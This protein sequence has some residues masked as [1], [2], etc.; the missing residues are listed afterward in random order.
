MANDSLAGALGA[1]LMQFGSARR[2]DKKMEL[3]ARLEQEREERAERYR[4]AAEQRAEKR[5]LAEVK[6]TELQ[7]DAEGALW[8]VT[9]NRNGDIL[10]RTLASRDEIEDRDFERRKRKVGLDVVLSQLD[11]SR[12][13]VQ[14]QELDI[15][16][17]EED[18]AL[19]RRYKE[20]MIEENEAQAEGGGGRGRGVAPVD[21]GDNISLAQALG[22]SSPDIIRQI[23]K[24]GVMN[25]AQ[26][27]EWLVGI[28]L[29]AKKHRKD[30][31]QVLVEQAKVLLAGAGD[32][33]DDE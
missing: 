11:E 5:A 7:E 25:A 8:K 33:E 30:A 27:Q 1:A 3:M 20:S 22:K 15:G 21:M 4:I 14:K 6:E 31:R 24:S 18:R 29:T 28:I 10:S 9:R 16:S 19:E 23:T 13:R 26:L 17:Y 32:E 2:E 12:N